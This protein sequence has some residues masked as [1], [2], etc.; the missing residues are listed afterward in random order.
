MRSPA[1]ASLVLLAWHP[2]NTL[3]SGF[4]MSF[5]ATMAWLILLEY[6]QKS[7][8][9][10][11]RNWFEKIVFWLIGAI[12]TSLVAGIATIPIALYN[13]QSMNTYGLSLIHI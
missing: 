9:T 12:L 7:D 10:K 2:E 13:F 8:I 5:L 1:I 6:C 3:D 4:M 11:P